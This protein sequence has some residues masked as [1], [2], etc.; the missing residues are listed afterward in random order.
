MVLYSFKGGSGDGYLPLYGLTLDSTGALYGTTAGGG[1]NDSGCVFQLIPT[2]HGPWTENILYF[3]LSNLTNGG[4]PNSGVVFDSTGALYGATGNG[5][6]NTAGT[7]FQLSPPSAPGG[8]WTENT[9]YVFPQNATDAA[10]PNGVIFA[11]SGAL[12]G[13]SAI[14]GTATSCDGGYGCGTIFKLIPP[15]TQGGVWTE[16][17]VYSFEGGSDGEDPAAPLALVGKTFYGT[18]VIG[19]TPNVG[20]VFSFAP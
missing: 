14:G 18:T 8:A 1:P 11:S 10:G 2:S 7:I 5:V 9:L 4:F 12:Y 15:S 13:T 16:Q 17:V 19:G 3:F 6:Y 20:T